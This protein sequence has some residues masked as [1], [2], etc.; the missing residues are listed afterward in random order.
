MIAFH[1]SQVAVSRESWGYVVAWHADR[2]PESE[3]DLILQSKDRFD[4]QDVRLG[5]NDVYIETCGQG[6]SWYGNIESFEFANECAR[7][8]LSA[9]AALRMM[10]DGVVEV[11]FSLDPT[12]LEELRVA[13]RHIFSGRDYYREKAV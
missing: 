3:R 13:L 4:E 9:A 8:T 6:W 12:K 5:M 7:V 2:D 1:A 11:T 10:D